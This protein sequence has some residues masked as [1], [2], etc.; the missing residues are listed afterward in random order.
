MSLT[1][2]RDQSITKRDRSWIFLSETCT[3]SVVNNFT[4]PQNNPYKA[5]TVMLIWQYLLYKKVVLFLL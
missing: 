4:F 3:I 2:V 5:D 1:R